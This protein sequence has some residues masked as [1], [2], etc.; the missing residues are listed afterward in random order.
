MGK[1]Y[2]RKRP[3][4][5]LKAVNNIK[6]SKFCILLLG[7]GQQREEIIEFSLKNNIKTILPGHKSSN[8][9]IDYF[10]IADVYL[11]LSDYDPSPKS[12]NEAMNFSLPVIVSTIVG[13][14]NDLV[15]NGINGF[16]VPVGNINSISKFIKKLELKSV[17]KTMG[18]KSLDIVSK[19]SIDKHVSSMERT[20]KNL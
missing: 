6:K 7:N 10:S 8:D 19:F 13:T 16:K 9:V 17:R 3:L 15:F 2:K 4:D 18:K 12:L 1:L 11:Q 5:I 14:C 20:I